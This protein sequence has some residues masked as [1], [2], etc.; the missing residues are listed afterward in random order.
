MIDFNNLAD[1]AINNQVFYCNGVFA[2]STDWQT[3]EK[4]KN[5]KYVY[6]TAIGSGGGGGGGRRS[7][8]NTSSGGG[9]GGSGAI[10]SGFFQAVV[11]PDVLFIQVAQGGTAG[12]GQSVQVNG[13]AGG[14]GKASIVSI[15]PANT[16]PF[17]VVQ[18]GSLA[19]SAV[20][21]AG[22][23]LAAVGGGAGEGV[24]GLTG[25]FANTG[26]ITS[27][28]GQLG[29]AGAVSTTNGISITPTRITTAGAGGGG[30]SS[31][32][33]VSNGGNI[34]ATGIFPLVPGTTGNSSA[35]SYTGPDAGSGYRTRDPGNSYTARDPLVCSGGAAGGGLVVTV[36]T[37]YASNGGNAAF[38]SGGG[39]GGGTNLSTGDFA[40]SGDGGRGGDGLVIITC[41]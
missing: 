12:T 23:A 34:T 40:R 24:W 13:I 8:S 22:G 10:S 15:R 41:F 29:G 5:C 9:G 25:A 36:G 32:T 26:Q 31:S 37:G 39:G 21:G 35:S 7:T 3:W 28:Q 11:L 16:V 17:V 19:S 2:N 20:G 38:G 18:S 6:I 14:F 1:N 4:P 30:T 33:A 27:I